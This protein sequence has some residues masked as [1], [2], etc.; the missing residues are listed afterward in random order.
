MSFA[1][2]SSPNTNAVM[3]SVDHRFYGVAA[4]TLAT[5][6]T[7]GQMFSI[8]IAMLVLS[9]F[10]GHEAITAESVPRFL[11]AARVT[12]SVFACLCFLGTLASLA[13]GNAA[14]G[15]RSA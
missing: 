4:G 6:R 15:G 1:L 14:V 7:L 8:G 11:S 13:R 3:S 10:M 2:F 9:L 12:F 5:M